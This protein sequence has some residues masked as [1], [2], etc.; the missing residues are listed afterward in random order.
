MII[1]Y[2]RLFGSMAVTGAMFIVSGVGL[3]LLGVV[4]EKRR[5]TLLRKLAESSNSPKL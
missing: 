2:A 4:I 3:I 5:R 1:A